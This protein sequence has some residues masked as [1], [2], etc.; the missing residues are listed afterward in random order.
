MRALVKIRPKTAYLMGCK[1]MADYYCETVV[2]L[3]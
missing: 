3:I 2:E 1:R